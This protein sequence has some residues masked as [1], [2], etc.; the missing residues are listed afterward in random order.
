MNEEEFENLKLF[1]IELF[2]Q[3][4]EEFAEYERFTTA[5]VRTSSQPQTGEDEELWI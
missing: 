4:L 2:K 1:K 5:Y 3:A